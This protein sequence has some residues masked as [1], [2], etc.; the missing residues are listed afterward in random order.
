MRSSEV[1]RGSGAGRRTSYALRVSAVSGHHP[2]ASFSRTFTRFVFHPPSG[3]SFQQNTQSI[4]MSITTFLCGYSRLNRCPLVADSRHPLRSGYSLHCTSLP[5]SGCA[6]SARHDGAL[7][8]P[9]PL[10]AKRGGLSLW[11]SFSL[12]TQRESNSAAEG[13]RKLSPA[14]AGMTAVRGGVEVRRLPSQA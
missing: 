13:R 10:C 12:A 6:P 2:M 3:R 14:F 1:D 4:A 11:L 7:L 9:G 8:Y 5:R